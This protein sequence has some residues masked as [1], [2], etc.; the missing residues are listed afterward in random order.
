MKKAEAYWPL[1]LL[2]ALV[3]FILPLFLQSS[4]YELQRDE[5]L[6]YEQGQHL[7][8]G[9][10]ENPPL[11]SYLGTISSW[12]GGSEAWIKFW[13]CLFGAA[14]VVIT[15]LIV[16]EFGGKLFAQFL[17]GLGIITGAYMRVHFLFQ[18]NMLDIFFWT[19][20]IYFIIRYLNDKQDKFIYGFTISLA[21]GFWSKYSVLFIAA[22]LL[23]ALLLSTHRKIFISK[24]FYIA[25][26]IS[27]L[28]ILPNVYWQYQHN[29]PLLHHMQELQ[30]T[31]LK[32]MNPLDFITEQFMMLLPVVLVWVAGVVW[33]LKHKQ[34]RFLAY[35]FFLVILFLVLG[36]GKSYY[37]L[38]IYPMLLAAGAV[39][40]EQWTEKRKWIRYVFAIIIIGFTGMIT[41]MLLPIWEPEK[42][43]AFHK[44]V[45]EEH[46]WEDQQIHP[47]PQDFADMLGWKE[48]TLKT[49]KFYNSL[50]DTIKDKTIIFGRHYGHAGSI[51]FYG[52]GKQFRENAMTDVGSF[53]LW[54]PDR[55]RMEHII[56][57]A[58]RMPDKDD[59][60]FQHFER[61]T[62]IDS[63]TNKL[64]RQYGDKVIF[65]ENIDSTGLRLAQEGLRE[66]KKEFN[67]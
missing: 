9:Y 59:E 38:G 1:I 65:F 15:C 39:I 11:L 28:I 47:L 42:L 57:I 17:G 29:W 66:M 61:V 49:E 13:P 52:K 32:Y 3:K 10:L 45:G 23:L 62:V 64:S 43:A 5:F 67:H 8:L 44:K 21:L 31:Q 14:T 56:L 36:R 54:I 22:G 60:V 4:V 6:Y 37:S 27:L 2:L 53:L 20:A 58:R 40:W 12:F 48:L 26:A 50:P 33:L 24:K 63:V 35:S 25:S 30:E 55:L 41:P 7:A 19:L 51:K 18:P 16:A 46:K 34:W